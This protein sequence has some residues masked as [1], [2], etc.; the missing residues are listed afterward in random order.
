MFFLDAKTIHILTKRIIDITAGIMLI[1]FK[2]FSR[3]Q[4]IVID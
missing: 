4:K 2:I 1:T 3:P